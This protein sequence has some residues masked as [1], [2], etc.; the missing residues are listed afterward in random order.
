MIWGAEDSGRIQLISPI[1]IQSARTSLHTTQEDASAISMSINEGITISSPAGV[2]VTEI[3]L[4]AYLLT[5]NAS[6][7][8]LTS[9]RMVLLAY[10]QVTLTTV[11]QGGVIVPKYTM[12]FTA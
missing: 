10:D 9:S 5:Y 3:G 2:T 12:A 7:D 11:S 4:Y 1:T 8:A 6:H